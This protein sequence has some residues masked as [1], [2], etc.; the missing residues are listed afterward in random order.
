MGLWGNKSFH[1]YFILACEEIRNLRSSVYRILRHLFSLR[2]KTPSLYTNLLG[3]RAGLTYNS[4]HLKHKYKALVC[5]TNDWK[6]SSIPC[7]L[8]DHGIVIMYKSKFITVYWVFP[9]KSLTSP[10]LSSHEASVHSISFRGQCLT[11]SQ[12]SYVLAFPLTFFS[13]LWFSLEVWWKP[14]GSLVGEE[15]KVE[16]TDKA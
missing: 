8:W 3:Q 13:H 1:C 4:R 10:P 14:C 9:F 15:T 5:Y 7:C 11:C 6:W 12:P 2:T 16:T